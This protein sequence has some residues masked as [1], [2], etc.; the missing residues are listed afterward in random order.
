[1]LARHEIEVAILRFE[2][3]LD[4]ML[5]DL[6]WLEAPTT[7]AA[8]LAVDPFT[9]AEDE[10]VPEWMSPEPPPWETSEEDCEPGSEP[11]PP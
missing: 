11:S 2:Q 8:S 7:L 3:C 4:E 9:E 6:P 5:T 10:L 1:M